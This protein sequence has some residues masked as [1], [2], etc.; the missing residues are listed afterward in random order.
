MSS[1]RDQLAEGSF[2]P[3]RGLD[4]LGRVPQSSRSVTPTTSTTREQHLCQGKDQ[5]GTDS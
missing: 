1:G 3:L 5:Q 2:S 4:H